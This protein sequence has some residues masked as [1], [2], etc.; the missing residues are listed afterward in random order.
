[1]STTI[2]EKFSLRKISAHYWGYAKKY[3]FLVVIL[4]LMPILGE[5]FDI[6]P[7]YLL[8]DLINTIANVPAKNVSETIFSSLLGLFYMITG[9]KILQFLTF[10][11][12]AYASIALETKVMKKLSDDF[13]SYVH[14]HS[15]DFFQNR[16]VGS[17]VKQAGRYVDAFENILDQIIYSIIPLIAQFIIGQIV[18]TSIHWMFGL[19]L[20]IWTFFF[21][22]GSFW[23]AQKKSTYDINESISASKLSGHLADSLS[24]STA[25]K[26]F[27]GF[28]HEEEVFHERTLDL[29]IQQKKKWYFGTI[30]DGFQG[31]TM[32]IM[33]TIILWLALHLWRE[34]LVTPGDIVLLIG[35]SIGLF[36][37]LWG[38]GRSI[39]KLYSSFTYCHEMLEILETPYAVQDSQN[40]TE[41]E[42]KKGE[43][44]F[45]DITFGYGKN[46]ILQNFV[47]TLKAGE[48][49]A[50]VGHSGAGKSTLIKLLLR[51]NDPLKG[52]LQ[53]D[54]QAI[55]TVTQDSLHKAIAY[56][57][58]EPALFHRTIGE[59]I[60]YAKPNATKEEIIE[61]AKRAHAHEFICTFPQ[62]YDTFVG[63]RGVKLSGG[64][65]QR[66]A[67]ARAMLA[68]A[69]ILIL[70]EATSSLDSESEKLI[71]DAFHTLMQ[72]KTTLVVAH[73]LST[74]MEMDR[75][76]VLE[77]GE[78][79]EEGT[80]VKL[81]EQ[82]G[83][84]KKLWSIQSG[85]FIGE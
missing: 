71:Q 17:L 60:A 9:Y 3:P 63:E 13:F 83:L 84:Y 31:L 64:E 20:A 54:N 56:V 44:C 21:L 24:N 77:K 29:S 59:N 7:Q 45:K 38:L 6:L 73:R 47:L 80:H 68:N 57:P 79:I 28:K 4:L 14:G 18:L 26:V 50:L 39:Q 2:K 75:I 81:L 34:G 30:G 82:N 35:A 51:F 53:I 55:N 1:M 49:V 42:I 5:V 22:L 65:R 19:A 43:V 25:V 72:G 85:G 70:D 67:I 40:A 61:A 62:G 27:A 36:R 16:F 37:R 32:I 33:E 12:T 66:I 15:I 10:R 52:S 46:I 23:F 11:C 76:L 41:L 69:P 74:I 8:R 48:R 78:I 58:Q